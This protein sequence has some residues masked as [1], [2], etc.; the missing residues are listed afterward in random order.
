M[1]CNKM[2]PTFWNSLALI[3]HNIRTKSPF[4]FKQTNKQTNKKRYK[5]EIL[6]FLLCYNPVLV[7]ELILESRHPIPHLKQ[8]LIKYQIFM[9]LPQT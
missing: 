2:H 5:A 8:L 1:N 7:Q 3:D 4:D 6:L 9:E